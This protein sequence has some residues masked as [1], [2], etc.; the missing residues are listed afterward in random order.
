MV[1][2][3][4]SLQEQVGC[5]NHRV[6]DPGC[7]Q[8]GETV[9]RFQWYRRLIAQGNPRAAS[10]FIFQ[11]QYTENPHNICDSLTWLN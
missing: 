5:F 4:I 9:V 2:I 6:V 11:P 3:Y 10:Q 1:Y 7:R 8:T